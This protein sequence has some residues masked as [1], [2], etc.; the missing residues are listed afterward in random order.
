MLLILVWKYVSK[1]WHVRLAETSTAFLNADTYCELYINGIASFKNA[2]GQGACTECN[3]ARSYD[4]KSLRSRLKAMD[5]S[6]TRH[7]NDSSR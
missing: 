6:T 7:V 4:A 3:V 2:K 5:S 1:I